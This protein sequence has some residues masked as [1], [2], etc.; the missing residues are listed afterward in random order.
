VNRMF[1]RLNWHELMDILGVDRIKKLLTKESI[2]R[3]RFPEL[4]E[5]YEFIRK[6]LSREP[7]SFTGWGDA[8]HQRIKHTLFSDRW[9]RSKPTLL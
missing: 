6:I 2:S 8:Y 4:R 7:V 3:I 9:Y 5:R 1:E